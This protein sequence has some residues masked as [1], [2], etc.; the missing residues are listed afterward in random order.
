MTN[1]LKEK[2]YILA[3]SP[4]SVDSISVDLKHHEDE[5]SW[6]KDTA[7]ECCSPHGSQEAER[8]VVG[9]EEQRRKGPGIR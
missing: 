2:R 1:N 5:T 6:Q 7:E 3:H 4:W 9:R 8:E